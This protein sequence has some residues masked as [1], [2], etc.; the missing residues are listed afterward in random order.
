ML[1]GN[2]KKLIIVGDEK[3]DVYC[4]Y[5]S[6]LISCRDDEKSENEN[7]KTVGIVD[8]TVDSAIW[9][10]EIYRNNRCHTSSR[11]KILFIGDS[12]S[13]KNV[14]PNIQCFD[15]NNYGVI[16][17]W[18]GNKAVINADVDVFKKDKVL[19]QKFYDEYVSL[20]KEYNNK[21]FDIENEKP[22]KFIDERIKENLDKT[23]QVVNSLVGKKLINKDEEKQDNIKPSNLDMTE[24]VP[25]VGT[26]SLAG[27]SISIPG[28][29]P[30]ILGCLPLPC[31]SYI[32]HEAKESKI[33]YD[34]I[35]EQQFRYA[36]LKFYL[37][38]FNAFMELI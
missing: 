8:G 18:L 38:Y 34:K 37:N 21:L 6:M 16:I 31:I 23:K 15:E 25:L 26:T 17:G 14:A 5:L 7:D 22:A 27:I 3:S 13:S 24:V 4:E 33:N 12:R 20:V 2:I 10:D 29:A 19:Y 36:V 1:N 28:V 32:A 9:T 30:M 11:Q 35:K